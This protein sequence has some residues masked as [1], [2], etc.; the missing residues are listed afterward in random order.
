MRPVLFEL[1]GISVY[2]YGFM[3]ALAFALATFAVALTAR[4]RGMDP[5]HVL[6][7]GIITCVAAIVGARLVFIL[8][9]LSYYLEQPARMVA[10]T[11]GGLSFHGGLA[12]GILSGILYCRFR[13]I[14]RWV[15][16]DMVAPF[17]A[18]GY[19]IVRI[20]CFLRG[21]C[22]G[23]VSDVHWAVATSE[24][25][26]LPRHPTQLYSSLLSLAL[27]L[28]LYS[29]RNHTG[30]RGMLMFQYVG[31]Y[32][33]VRFGVEFVREGQR[34]A[35][36]LTLAQLVSIVVAVIAFSLVGLLSHRSR[37]AGGNAVDTRAS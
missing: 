35:L 14:D 5:N 4:R 9:N 29:R 6:D 31:L 12:A 25:D 18:L 22:Y 32:S 34:I 10:I 23:V 27:F 30:F 16:A 15:M 24:I 26:D 37:T 36:G 17:V 21:C 33:L 19:S 7:L 1:F 13:K 2:S 8:L 3:L 11:D 28:Y 20:G